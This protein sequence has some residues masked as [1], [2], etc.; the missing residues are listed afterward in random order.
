MPGRKR[1]AANDANDLI[2]HP[3]IMCTGVGQFVGRGD[4]HGNLSDPWISTAGRTALAEDLVQ[5]I[6][7][8]EAGRAQSS[9]KDKIFRGSR[10]G[11]NAAGA[12]RPF[13]Q[14][15][16]WAPGQPARGRPPAQHA[17]PAS[18]GLCTVPPRAAMHDAASRAWCRP[19]G[20]DC[21]RPRGPRAPARPLSRRVPSG[22]PAVLRGALSP[23]IPGGCERLNRM[24][25]GICGEIVRQLSNPQTK[26]DGQDA[27]GGREA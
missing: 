20:A 26:I 15:D 17:Q 6:D 21:S 8:S 23:E 10:S 18:R 13:R 14:P 27:E 9:A 19:G 5:R 16:A 3:K 2:Q 24:A 22:A 1:D 25:D 11:D 7:K 4:D 12:F